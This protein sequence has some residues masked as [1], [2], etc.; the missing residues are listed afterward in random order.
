M[1]WSARRTIS[2]RR[3]EIAASVVLLAFSL[4]IVWESLNMPAGT[5]GAPGPGYFPKALGTLLALASV[6]L[7][8]RALRIAPA[9][10]EAVD[11][12][13]RDIA[14]TVIALVG[15]G[16]L[17]ERAGYLVSSTLFMLV[18]LRAFSALGWARA[19]AAALVVSLATYYPFDKLLGV[20]LPRGI[21]GIL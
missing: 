15:L 6:G 18:L 21:L 17:F 5:A 10:D 19:L 12:G 20:T 2:L 7:F 16:L 3:G 13:H 11:L 1:T 4:A 9:A 8:V 14:L